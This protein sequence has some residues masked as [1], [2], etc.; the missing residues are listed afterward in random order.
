MHI[1]LM[2]NGI[3]IGTLSLEQF[4]KHAR[5]TFGFGRQLFLAT[6]VELFNSKSQSV[7]AKIALK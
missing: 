7:K 4:A 3:V 1:Q 6:Y 2:E 5:E